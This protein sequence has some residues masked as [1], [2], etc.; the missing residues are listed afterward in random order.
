MKIVVFICQSGQIFKWTISFGSTCSDQGTK[1]ENKECPKQTGI[2][3]YLTFSPR[4]VLIPKSGH[5]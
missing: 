5:G 3:I 2:C 4:N 1:G